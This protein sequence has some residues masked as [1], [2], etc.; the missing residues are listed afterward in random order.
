MGA[1]PKYCLLNTQSV[2]AEVSKPGNNDEASLAFLEAGGKDSDYIECP[3][4]SPEWLA[5]GADVSVRQMA[6]WLTAPAAGSAE[7]LA[8]SPAAALALGAR[9]QT[10]SGFICSCFNS[11]LRPFCLG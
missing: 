6:D 11:C 2:R 9:Q 7:Q 5:A 4:G 8:A 1:S 10:G 3:N